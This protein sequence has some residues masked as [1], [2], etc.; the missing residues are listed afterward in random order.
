[1]QN[2]DGNLR[3]A[4]VH[5]LY[6]ERPCLAINKPP[7]LLTQAPPSIDSVEVRVKDLF[8]EREGIS[9]KVYVGVPHRIDRPASGVLVLARHVRAARRL[10]EQFEARTV[11][12]VY[13]AIVEGKLP[14]ESDVWEDYVRKVPDE[15]RAEIVDEDAPNSRR[16]TLHYKVLEQFESSSWLEIELETG[17]YHQIR[18]QAAS[19]GFAILGDEQYGSQTDFGP[20]H[21]DT[22]LRAIALHARQLQFAHPMTHE[23]VNVV[24]PV[25]EP[26]SAFV[27]PMNNETQEAANPS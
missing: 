4:A 7:G 17:R 16:A 24:A 5:V 10:A 23:P 6:D 27:P 1:M 21:E 22:R 20:Q 15:P 14:M 25:P 11:R 2:A 9:G 19:R 12:K 8:R 3:S 13:W 18:V 26:W